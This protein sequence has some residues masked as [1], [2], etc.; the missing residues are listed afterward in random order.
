MVIYMGNWVMDVVCSE[1]DVVA[2][3]AAVL[4]LW[5]KWMF[6]RTTDLF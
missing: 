6:M 3:S 2:F 5:W 1:N 4:Q